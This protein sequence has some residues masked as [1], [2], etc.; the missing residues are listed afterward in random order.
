MREKLNK[1]LS[2]NDV[3]ACLL[4]L[5]LVLFFGAFFIY[6]LYTDGK[7]VFNSKVYGIAFPS[8]RLL[9]W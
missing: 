5:P 8:A 1:F 4:L 6:F 9:L 2:R 3:K 7:D